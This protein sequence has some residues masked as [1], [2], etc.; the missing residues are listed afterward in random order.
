M[1]DT[2]RTIKKDKLEYSE[3]WET[4]YVGKNVSDKDVEEFITSI[5]SDGYKVIHVVESKK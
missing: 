3:K 1:R 4:V 2:Y 5:K